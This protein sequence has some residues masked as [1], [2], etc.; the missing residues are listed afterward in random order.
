[1]YECAH[2][3]ASTTEIA[4]A[5]TAA[6]FGS[7]AAIGGL[8]RRHEVHHGNDHEHHDGN[9]FLRDAG[10]DMPEAE[11]ALP[12]LQVEEHGDA[13][14]CQQDHRQYAQQLLR[15]LARARKRKHAGAA[16]HAAGP[17]RQRGEQDQR[18]LQFHYCSPPCHFMRRKMKRPL[19]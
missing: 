16:E 18:P 1:M 17:G 6:H 15:L 5:S 2:T 7:D 12:V 14:S 10:R 9:Q 8:A 11:D 13:G 4:T 19:G 3:A